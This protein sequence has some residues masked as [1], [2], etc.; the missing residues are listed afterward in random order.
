MAF[1]RQSLNVNGF[2]GI[3]TG[4]GSDYLD[5]LMG[6][7]ACGVT[8]PLWENILDCA[9]SKFCR[10]P[11]AL[12]LVFGT[13]LLQPPGSFTQLSNARR[14]GF[15]TDNRAVLA[16]VCL[17]AGGDPRSPAGENKDARSLS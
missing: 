4:R 11:A 8:F 15:E 3:Y 1:V 7:L 17:G 16:C 10:R 13:T 2:I 14:E 12:Q 5:S 6:N 9:A